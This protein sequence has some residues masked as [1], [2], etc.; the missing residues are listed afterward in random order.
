MRLQSIMVNGAGDGF[1]LSMTV[2]RGWGQKASISGTKNLEMSRTL[3]MTSTPVTQRSER[4]LLFRMLSG[5]CAYFSRSTNCLR[6]FDTLGSM[7][8]RQ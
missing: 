7:I 2:P 8:T 6:N 5:E 1:A 4:S 3:G